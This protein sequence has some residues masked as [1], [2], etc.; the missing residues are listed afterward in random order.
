MEGVTVKQEEVGSSSSGISP[1]PMEGLHDAGPPPFLTKTFDMV[2]D[3][4]T[5]SIV[6]W[7]P[8]RNSFIVWDAHKADDIQFSPDEMVMGFAQFSVCCR[9][10]SMSNL[11][12]GFRKVDPDRWEFA[13]EGFLGGQR[14]LLKNIK[15][16]RH[17]S[18]HLQ[19]PQDMGVCV[20]I[21][22]FGLD[23]EIEQL[24][25]DRGILVAEIVKLRLQQQTSRSQLATMEE[26]LRGTE[27]KQQQM[28]AFLARA[29][30][31]PTFVQQLIKSHEQKKALGVT[32][33]KRRLTVSAST[34]NLQEE[35]I[36]AMSDSTVSYPN[37]AVAEE[38]VIE[39]EI[40]KLFST[41]DN[42]ESSSDIDQT[43]EVVP[44]S[45]FEAMA[46]PK[47]STLSSGNDIMWEEL[48]NEELIAGN[49][50]EEGELTEIDVEVEDLAVRPSDWGDDVNFLVKQMG[51]LGPNP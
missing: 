45:M 2:E 20:E 4:T 21:G 23:G 41:M 36:S 40:E 3:T 27:R 24:R 9:N 32:G 13:N 33:R 50:D 25:R 49:L 29:L 44:N 42:I 39:N 11:E 47:Q 26:R 14:H 18:Q 37:Q 8:G 38:E 51:F 35:V 5:D 43:V 16:R 7:S 17:V 31:N 28:M 34:E 22:Q 12:M 46:G 6:S 10:V 1:Q 19:Q 15:R 30:N 48:L